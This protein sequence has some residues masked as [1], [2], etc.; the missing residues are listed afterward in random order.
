MALFTLMLY[1]CHTG[2]TLLPRLASEGKNLL[3]DPSGRG[4]DD[5]DSGGNAK[6]AIVYIILSWLQGF[7]KSSRNL[8]LTIAPKHCT[9][10]ARH[11]HMV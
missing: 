5:N 1:C 2:Y 3:Q 7:L 8:T 6:V 10:F 11:H 4:K 9:G